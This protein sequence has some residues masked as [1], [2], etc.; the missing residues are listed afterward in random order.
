M[1]NKIY[2]KS[3]NVYQQKEIKDIEN[4]FQVFYATAAVIFASIMNFVTG[5]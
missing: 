5:W 1:C 4:M 2:H 3:K